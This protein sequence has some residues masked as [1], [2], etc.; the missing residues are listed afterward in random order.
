[1]AINSGFTHWKWWFSIVML[2]YQRVMWQWTVMNNINVNIYKRHN[3]IN[4]QLSNHNNLNPQS[5]EHHPV[6]IILW[7]SQ[8]FNGFPP[9]SAFVSRGG[10]FD[11]W[12][13]CGWPIC[14]GQ[15]FTVDSTKHIYSN[16]QKDHINP[17]H[18]NMSGKSCF[19]L[20]GGCHTTLQDGA[21][22]L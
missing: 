19:Y 20:F 13:N 7:T 12:Q 14:Q 10:K 17:N 22:Q 16:R 3:N 1:M 8:M 15:S 5:C 11:A 21:P 4:E 2:V 6:N 18:G 9:G